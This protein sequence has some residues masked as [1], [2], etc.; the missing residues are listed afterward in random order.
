M[1]PAGLSLAPRHGTGFSRSCDGRE[2]A[3][4]ARR[5]YFLLSIAAFTLA[6][7]LCGMATSLDE[8][9]NLLNAHVRSF[10]G[11]ARD[12]FFERTGDPAGSVRSGLQRLDDLR[13]Q[14]AASLADFDV[15]WVCAVLSVALV[16]L[17]LFMKRSVAEKGQ[18]AGAE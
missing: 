10:L 15:F 6:S 14:Q 18:H 7:A 9:L 4:L 13:Q 1:P 12:F 5:N 3:H 11:R 2:R 17:V 8:T 16:V